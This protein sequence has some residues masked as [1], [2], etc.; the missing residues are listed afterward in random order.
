MKYARNLLHETLRWTGQGSFAAR[1]H[2]TE[3]TKLNDEITIPAG[4]PIIT[5]LGKVLLDPEIWDDAHIFNPD[6]FE[7]AQAKRPL[8]F[9]PFG[10][11]GGRICPG[12]LMTYAEVAVMLGS[13][14][15][16]Y[17]MTV[18][19]PT[20]PDC[21]YGIVTKPHSE[22]YGTFTRRN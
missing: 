14:F 2:E 15:K 1:V 12:R 19:T 10:F 9:S 7:D 8:Y 21:T 11:A 3:D 18:D 6:R 17:N 20:P 16:N 22:V 4:M 13:V 5:P